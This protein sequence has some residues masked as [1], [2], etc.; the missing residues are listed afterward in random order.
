MYQQPRSGIPAF[1][2]T[3]LISKFKSLWLADVEANLVFETLAG[4]AWGTLHVNPG[5]H[6]GQA[7]PPL[8]HQ[9][10]PHQKHESPAKQRR[11][12]R[13]KAARSETAAFE[14]AD[15]VAEEPTNSFDKEINENHIINSASGEVSDSSDKVVAE[16][17]ATSDKISECVDK[18]KERND[19]LNKEIKICDEAIEK[20]N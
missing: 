18:L 7:Q 9:E 13:R 16:E 12:E 6:P 14:T 10:R 15:M 2:T 19:Y 3:S 20:L 17:E 4:Q 1:E 11:R 8:H 5:E